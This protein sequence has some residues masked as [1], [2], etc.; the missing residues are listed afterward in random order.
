M[1]MKVARGSLSSNSTQWATRSW[2]R[3]S[4]RALTRGLVMPHPGAPGSSPALLARR[5]RS[6]R[7]AGL[8]PGV[9]GVTWLQRAL[10]LDD[11]VGLDHV[12]LAHVVVVLEGDAALEA[13]AHF[14]GVVLLAPQRRHGAG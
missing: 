12:A 1:V 13:L 10:D 2:M 8:E 7:G 9:P 14:L 4:M 6:G 5:G 3:A 11:L